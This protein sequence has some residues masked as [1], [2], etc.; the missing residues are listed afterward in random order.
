MDQGAFGHSGGITQIPRVGSDMGGG[1]KAEALCACAGGW[2]APPEG[3]RGV[4]GCVRARGG[5][6]VGPGG[7]GIKRPATSVLGREPLPRSA[8]SERGPRCAGKRLQQKGGLSS[9]SP[10]AAPRKPAWAH[11]APLTIQRKGEPLAPSGERRPVCFKKLCAPTVGISY[12][13]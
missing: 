3:A 11:Q 7:R 9:P 13:G 2:R 1:D 12:P 8:C 4:G 10:G 6:H 5:V